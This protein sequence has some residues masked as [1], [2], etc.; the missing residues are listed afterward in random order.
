MPH[1]PQNFVYG[2]GMVDRLGALVRGMNAERAF[3][4]T[5]PGIV[6]AGHCSRVEC[7][8]M[9]EGVQVRRFDETRE[10]PTSGDVARCVAAI[11]DWDP[12]V[13]IGVGG[14]SSIDLAKGSAFILAGGGEMED[15]RG[16]DAARG[17][18]KP[19]VAIPTTAGTGTEMQS[20]ALIGE[21]QTHRKMACGD[22]QAMPRLAL[23]DPE[24]T[25]SQPRFVT[26]CT[27]YDALGHA[28]ETAVTRDRTSTS[29]H[30]ASQ[31]FTALYEHLPTV[32][33]RPDD[34]T[35]RG[36]VM[37]AAAWAGW[38]IENSMLGAA[39]SM[40][41][42]LTSR[43]GMVHGQ[44]VGMCLPYVVRFNGADPDAA[45]AYGALARGAGLVPSDSDDAVA[46]D[47][48]V[49]FLVS[50]LKQCGFGVAL[51]GH[52][53][54]PDDVAVMAREASQQWT[55]QFNPRPVTEEDFTGLFRAALAGG[56]DHGP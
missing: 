26:A 20:F 35:A 32:L 12:D 8:L 28:V 16:H 37:L 42:P 51:Q 41:N 19:V 15:Y 56:I 10:N 24:L 40:A 6:A 47:G 23:L 4:V 13:L 45:A 7:S 22:P 33:E 43:H 5:D 29:S 34:L 49:E 36:E 9:E 21:E 25:V 3:V 30:F 46:V 53:V 54:D 48:L 55:A 14:G 27:G 17:T 38:A 2:P 52:G 44:A 1:P 18:L 50:L 31:A 11:G 39:H